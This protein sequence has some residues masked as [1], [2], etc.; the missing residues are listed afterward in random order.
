MS[1]HEYLGFDA[2]P[3]TTTNADE[4]LNLAE[5]FVPPPFYDAVLGDANSPSASVVL[6]PRGAG[7]TALRRML[8]QGSTKYRFMAVTYDR[9]EFGAGQTPDNITLNYH[10]RNI[11]CRVLVSYLSYIADYPDLLT[12]LNDADKKNIALFAKT[13]LGDLT[14]DKLQELLS[15]LKGLPDKFKAFWLK[16]VGVLESVVNWILKTQNLPEI[17]LPDAKQ[18]EKRLSETYKHQLKYL[19]TL[20]TAL[21]FKAIY[22][23]I[24]KPDETEHTGNNS[25]ATYSL[26]RP[27]LRDLELLG[28]RPYGFKFF[29]WDQIDSLYRKDAR[30]DRI[31]EYKLSWSR[32][33][34]QAVL[35]KRLKY[36]SNQHCANMSQIC[37]TS[38]AYDVDTAICVIANKSPRNVIRICEQI[39]A[40]QAEIANDARIISRTAVDRGV[41]T[42]CEQA[43]INTYG[44]N[45]I[46]DMQ[47]IGRELFTINFLAN[48]V[49]KVDANTVRNKITAWTTMGLVKQIGSLVVATSKK[50]LN[51]Y[52]VVDPA[53]VRIIHRTLSLD[54]FLQTLWIPCNF[55]NT[56]NLMGLDIFSN[57]N[58][59]LC[60]ECGRSLV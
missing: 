51:L 38:H 43:S 13:Y 34:L 25:G 52:C 40:A 28:L 29:L 33:S 32:Q 20:V 39:L 1:L 30:P 44:G 45:V 60:L 2:Q 16:N 59:P 9:Y 18:E 14:G 11:I 48:E 42:Y 54:V 47:R 58:P 36:F 5:Y 24:D 46:K 50:P 21:G 7:K 22:V 55:C 4:E 35:S 57:D 6:A 56:D 23:L 19:S 12:K 31:H 49:F 17:D 10:L 15:E 3:F 27:L 26:I 41:L 53:V 8:E 37:E